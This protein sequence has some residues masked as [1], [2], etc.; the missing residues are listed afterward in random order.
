MGELLAYN[1]EIK[2][3]YYLKEKI[4]GIQQIFVEI[5][6]ICQY[7]VSC[8]WTSLKNDPGSDDN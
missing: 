5:R 4:V 3:K 7:F 8:I 1:R 6:F 2:S